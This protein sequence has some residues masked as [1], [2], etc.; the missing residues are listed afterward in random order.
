MG[1]KKKDT[2]FIDGIFDDEVVNESTTYKTFTFLNYDP[3]HC[4]QF[5]YLAKISKNIYNSS[6]Y[7]IQIFN[8]FKFALFKK[9]FFALETNP[10]INTS[11]FINNKLLEYHQ[12]YSNINPHIKSN[13]NYI[14]SCIINEIKTTNLVIKTSNIDLSY[15]TISEEF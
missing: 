3:L 8:K 13:N 4:Q 7:C 6:I 9:L 11:L 14:Y 2:D 5:N 1:K 12:L 15:W 10:S